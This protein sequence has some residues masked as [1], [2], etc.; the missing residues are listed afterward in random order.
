[1]IADYVLLQ[2][3]EEEPLSKSRAL[4]AAL[5]KDW[6]RRK[7]ATAWDV[8]QGWQTQNPPQHAPPAPRVVALGL[9]TWLVVAGQLGIGL[10][11][12]L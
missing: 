2:R 9:V 11:V 5:Q 3:D 6:P 7:F 10:A 4:V 12:R 8:V 1:M